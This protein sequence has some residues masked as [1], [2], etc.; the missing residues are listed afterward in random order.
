M[1]DHDVFECQRA[2]VSASALVQRRCRVLS[3]LCSH[4]GC[5]YRS[6]GSIFVAVIADRPASPDFAHWPELRPPPI[7]VAGR[8]RRGIGS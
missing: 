1:P 5:R 2:Y 7:A 3:S 8:A 4:F 6:P